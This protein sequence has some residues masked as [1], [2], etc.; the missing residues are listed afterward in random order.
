MLL[1]LLDTERKSAPLLV[2]LEDL[3]VGR[4]ARLDNL[5]G[6]LDVMVGELGDVDQTL[7]AGQDLDEGAEGDDLGDC[8]A[9][10]VTGAMGADHPL[11]RVLLGLL[12]AQ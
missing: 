12:Q 7:D 1:D 5:A 9:E 3:D 2:D 11:P 8:A 6:A 10:H 4:G